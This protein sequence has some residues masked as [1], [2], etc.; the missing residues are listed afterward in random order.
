MTIDDVLVVPADGDPIGYLVLVPSW[1]GLTDHFRAVAARLAEAGFSTAVVD[2]YRGEQTDDP[3]RARQLRS[4][5]SDDELIA[6]A[7]AAVRTAQRL[8]AGRPIGLVGFSVGAE[9]VIRVAARLGADAGAVVAFYGVCVPADL[10]GLQAP[11]SVHLAGDDEFVTPEEVAEFVGAYLTPSRRLE[12]NSY[13]GTRHAFFNPT[14]LEAYDPAA[15]D[16]S[17]TRALEF[18]RRTLG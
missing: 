3:A 10:D 12:L 11:V 17:W 4:A 14:R 6:R 1:W 16:L 2:L 5:L 9:T 18:L 7:D 13:P 15:A 8:A